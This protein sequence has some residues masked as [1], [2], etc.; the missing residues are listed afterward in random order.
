MVRAIERSILFQQPL[1][2]AAPAAKGLSLPCKMAPSTRSLANRAFEQ[3]TGSAFSK[4]DSS[5]MEYLVYEIFREAA[6]PQTNGKTLEFLLDS[7]EDDAPQNLQPV[8]IKCLDLAEANP[9]LSARLEMRLK[10]LEESSFQSSAALGLTDDIQETDWSRLG[11]L[12]AAALTSLLVLS[13]LF[14]ARPVPKTEDLPCLPSEAPVGPLLGEEGCLAAPANLTEST[15]VQIPQETPP[16]AALQTAAAP[17]RQPLSEE[18]CPAAPANQTPSSSVQIP[19]ETPPP[20]AVQTAA[21]P[22]LSSNLDGLIE[23]VGLPAGVTRPQVEQAVA[24][25]E[26]RHKLQKFFERNREMF[27]PMKETP[28]A[29]EPV[30]NPP[31]ESIASPS[32]LVPAAAVAA[33]VGIV[34]LW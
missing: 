10:T 16:P 17:A 2:E 20:A 22:A 23:T 29:P 1:Q 31:A 8:L 28:P 4:T 9:A 33:G 15:R 13:A 19:H 34:H 6:R 25:A 30:P 32:L 5:S 3:L 7:L 11:L 21:A 12:A 24:Y 18:S 27:V 26:A 14:G